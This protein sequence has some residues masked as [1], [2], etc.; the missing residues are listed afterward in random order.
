MLLRIGFRLIVLAL[1]ASGSAFALISRRG[2][3]GDAAGH[4]RAAV[5]R[6]G[7]EGDA[8]RR[9][10]KGHI[11]LPSPLPKSSPIFPACRAG[12]AHA[13]GCSLPR[14]Q[15]RSAATRQD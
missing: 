2:G 5:C 11:A 6:A 7:A 4:V 3:D 8:Q 1:I 15:R 14:W 12:G 13:S 9:E 10:G